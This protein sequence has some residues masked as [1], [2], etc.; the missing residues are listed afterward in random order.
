MTFQLTSTL[1]AATSPRM[2]QQLVGGFLAGPE[3][4]NRCWDANFS[5]WVGSWINLWSK[6]F[7]T[8]VS[9][10]LCRDCC[11]CAKAHHGRSVWHWC[12]S[13]SDWHLPHV[14][15]FY[16]VDF[17]PLPRAGLCNK[18]D[19]LGPSPIFFFFTT[20]TLFI[21]SWLWWIIGIGMLSLVLS[22]NFNF[23]K[24]NIGLSFFGFVIELI[25]Y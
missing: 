2:A 9:L 19:F 11:L 7:D 15:A 20:I 21:P 14:F 3:S 6:A 12:W 22:N 17:W 4:G 10:L 13:R 1:S 16:N 24:R 5:Q 8:L 23:W 25:E 18:D